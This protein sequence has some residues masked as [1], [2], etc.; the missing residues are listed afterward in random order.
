MRYR[1]KVT[2]LKQS[3]INL[4]KNMVKNDDSEVYSIDNNENNIN[5]NQDQQ[6]Q[7]K[8]SVQNWQFEIRKLTYED[9]G[10]YQCLLPLVNPIYKNITLQVMRKFFIFYIKREFFNSC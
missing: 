1:V 10:T 7:P 8:Y 6:T 3:N 5:N 4:T 2:D 9:A